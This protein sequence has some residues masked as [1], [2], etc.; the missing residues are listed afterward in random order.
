MGL[1]TKE[2]DAIIIGGGFGGVYHLHHLRKLGFNVHMF[3]AGSQL[4]GVWYWNC[5]PGARVDTECPV[6]QFSDSE[7]FK[8]WKWT[9]RYPGRDELRRYF[10]HVD[11]IWDLKKDISFNSRVT[12][13]HW[14]KESSQ[15]DVTVAQNQIGGTTELVARSKSILCCTGF[16]SKPYT[17]PFAGMEKFQG[18]KYHTSEWPQEGVDLK[19]KRVGVIGT[20]A[21]GVQVVQTVMPE[22]KELTVFQRTP[23]YA[24]PMGQYKITDERNQEFK[25]NYPELV[26]KIRSTFAGFLYDFDSGE[27]LKA[28]EEE[29][30]ELYERLYT[31]GG[32]HFWL[33][34]YQDVLKNK[35]A[36]DTAYKFWREKT[37]ARINDPATA[38]ILAP[39]VAPHPYGTK[40][41]SLEQNYFE[42]FNKDNAHVVDV[43]KNPIETFTANGIRTADGKEHELDVVVLATG[44]DSIS[45]GITL[46][47]I[48]GEDGTSLKDKWAQGV[49]TYLGMTSVG[50]PNMFM[51]YG[52]QAPT[53]FATGPCSAETQGEWIGQCLSHMRDQKLTT[54][55]PTEEAEAE[56]RTHVNDVGKQGLFSDTESW[57]FGTNIP[58]KPKEALNYMA[59]MQMYKQKCWES[60]NNGYRGFI[61]A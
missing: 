21:S 22:V 24:L 2:Y 16:A 5:Y 35:E 43:K 1:D 55:K 23:N 38:E 39:K 27:C 41:V 7:L 59:G 8:D 51:V 48:R 42:V 13:A 32:L 53:A 54:I 44:F 3:E 11:K 26:A 31:T 17:P 9:E 36:N 15:W 50:F 49:W 34:T 18:I 12:A 33:G 10:D 52:P 45:G 47:D 46:I 29:R 30:R 58:G 4:G 6:Y 57:Y 20:G 61:M 19:G 56:W 28:T 60:A 37:I 25:K 14:N 40:R